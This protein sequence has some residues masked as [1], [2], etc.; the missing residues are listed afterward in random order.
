MSALVASLSA[1]LTAAPVADVSPYAVKRLPDGSLEYAYDLTALKQA[2]LADANAAHGDEKVKAFQ[3]G[4]PK[5]VKLLVSPGAPIEV[6]AGRGPEGGRLANGFSTI[7]EGPMASANAF[8]DKGGPRLKPA[9]DPNEPKLLLSAEAVAWQVRD[10]E[11]SALAAVEVDTEALRRELWNKVME[12]ALQRFKTGQGDARE[13]ALALVARLAAGA[14]CLDGTKVAATVRADPDLSLAVDAEIARL[15]QSPDALLAPTPWNWRPE[16][17]CAWV[18]A[19]AMGQPFER[20]RGGTAAVLHFLDLVSADPKLAATWDRVRSRRDRFLGA[21]LEERVLAWREKAAGKPAAA[22]ENLSDFIE[23]LPHDARVPPPLVAPAVT[24]FGRFFSELSGIERAHAF[25]ELATAVQD[26]RV[27]PT[28]ASWPQARDAALA[29][30]CLPDA[31]KAVTLDGAWRDRL[32][33]AF[34][35][36]GGGHLESGGKGLAFEPDEHER[37]ELTVRLLAP[38]LLEVEPVP[39]YFSRAAVSL[40]RLVE[41]LQHEQLAGLTSLGADARRGG[42]IAGTART[43]IPK[44]KGLAALAH[45]EQQ[46]AKELAEGRKLAASWRTDPAF[47]RDVREASASPVSSPGERPHAAVVGVDRRELVV[48]FVKPPKL[49]AV[50]GPLSG[51]V[52]HP[53]EQRYIVPVLTTVGASAAPAVRPLDR[54]KLKSLVEASGRDAVQTEGAFSE[55]LKP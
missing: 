16:L 9:L 41:A 1:L 52:F 17:T 39:E 36:L 51:F 31:Q 49:E 47:S 2:N 40:E 10:L 32:Q 13:G 12:R 4:L 43:W 19:A 35:A 27:A 23:S 44:L 15:T 42:P 29:A 30:L 25:Q 33:A 6:S 28:T 26:G 7:A 55:S 24:P 22:I 45:P 21:P 37:S 38:P 14:A 3:K 54:V 18:R 20:S 46:G 50:G 48:S 53:G 8:G 34:G 11:L 5:S